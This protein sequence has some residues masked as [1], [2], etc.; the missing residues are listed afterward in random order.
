MRRAQSPIYRAESK[1]NCAVHAG[2]SLDNGDVSSVIDR[3]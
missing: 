2:H 1:V 3:V